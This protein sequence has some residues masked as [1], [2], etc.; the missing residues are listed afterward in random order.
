[1]DS[2]EVR[3][4]EAEAKLKDYAVNEQRKAGALPS[5]LDAFDEVDGPPAFLDP[6]ATRPLAASTHTHHQGA[7]GADGGPGKDKKRQAPGPDFDISK[8]APLLKGQK[9]EGE[10]RAAPAG[11]VLEAKA[12]RYKADDGP[13]ATQQYSAVQIA[14]L[15]GNVKG[16]VQGGEGAGG[17][18]PKS[19]HATDMKE[20]MAKGGAVPLPR[21]AA[22]RK[23]KEKSKRDRGQSGVQTWK[24]EAEMVLRQQY[25]S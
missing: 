25:D 1:L 18:K 15:G 17:G 24:S 16:P 8:L 22:D 14:M 6:E 13:E 2:A 12:Q 4:R 3:A 7:A 5:A 21:K 11:A 19:T 23:D 10:G 9:R 20:F